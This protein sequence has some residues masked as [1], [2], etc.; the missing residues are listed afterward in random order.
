MMKGNYVIL[1]KLYFTDVNL[2]HKNAKNLNSKHIISKKIKLTEFLYIILT[3]SSVFI[4]VNKYLFSCL[5][6]EVR[7]SFKGL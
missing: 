4:R 5:G 2:I 1:M 7:F 3:S 6:T